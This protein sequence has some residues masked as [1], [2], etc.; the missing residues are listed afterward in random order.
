MTLDKYMDI[1]LADNAGS[2]QDIA[3]KLEELGVS[4]KEAAKLNEGLL[5]VLFS[6]TS[7]SK[8]DN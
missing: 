5:A 4:K 6:R 7:P 3:K 1:V 2:D 8:H